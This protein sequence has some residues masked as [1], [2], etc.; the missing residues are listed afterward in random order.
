[1]ASV[2]IV[3]SWADDDELTISIEVDASYPDALDQARASAIRAYSD[4]L[5]I[6]VTSVDDDTTD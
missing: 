3:R 1:M 6:T 5:G 4:A 2:T